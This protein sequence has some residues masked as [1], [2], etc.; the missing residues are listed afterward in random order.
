MSRL[1]TSPF[2]W[3]PEVNVVGDP[4]GGEF[5]TFAAKGMGTME[6]RYGATRDTLHHNLSALQKWCDKQNE[7]E[8]C[9]Y[10]MVNEAHRTLKQYNG[11]WPDGDD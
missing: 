9:V 4:K 6:H 3:A 8:T 1:E 10:N 5:V 7:L 2:A 11:R